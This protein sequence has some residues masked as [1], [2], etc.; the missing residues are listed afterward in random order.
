MALQFY[1]CLLINVYMCIVHTH[2]CTSACG[3][4]VHVCMS[5]MQCMWRLEDNL[6][7]PS[8]GSV[9][10]LAYFC[11]GRGIVVVVKTGSHI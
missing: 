1:I 7:H 8:S 3:V 10:M 6:C 9:G 11:L 5:A 2:M 4:Y